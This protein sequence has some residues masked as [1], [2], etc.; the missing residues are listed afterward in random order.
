MQPTKPGS[1]HL[2]P[3]PRRRSSCLGCCQTFHEDTGLS[4]LR[5][6]ASDLHAHDH[7]PSTAMLVSLAT[8]FFPTSGTWQSP[9]TPSHEGK[10]W[11][12]PPATGTHP[13]VAVHQQRFPIKL[14]MGTQIHVTHRQI[15]SDTPSRIGWQ[16]SPTQPRQPKNPAFAYAARWWPKTSRGRHTGRSAVVEVKREPQ[17]VQEEKSERLWVNANATGP[18]WDLGNAAW[19]SAS[20]GKMVCW[21]KAESTTQVALLCHPCLG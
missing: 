10:L 17:T 13:T 5:P 9:T 3:Q 12:C 8:P 14:D 19:L 15:R 2:P 21:R 11:W 20:V 16:H 7:Q 4:R 18:T 1:T 6:A